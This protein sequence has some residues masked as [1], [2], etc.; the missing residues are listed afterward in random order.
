MENPRPPHLLTDAGLSRFV[1]SVALRDLSLPIVDVEIE[2]LIWHFDMPVWEKDGTDDWNLTPRD[3][4]NRN[5]GSEAHQKRV[6]E[7]N[8]SYP[9][10]VTKYKGRLVIL[11]GI[12][13]L[14]KGYEQG[15]KTIKAKIIPN[16]Y[17]ELRESLR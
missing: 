9:I 2:K 7:A 15:E 6:G 11:D 4:I 1:N 3:V 14:V 12:H 16:E 5:E 13:R 8:T 17:L 10:L